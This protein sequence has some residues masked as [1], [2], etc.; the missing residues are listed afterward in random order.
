MS[1]RALAADAA[2]LGARLM[3]IKAVRRGL[4]LFVRSMWAPKSHLAE[5][6]ESDMAKKWTPSNDE[7]SISRELDD[8]VL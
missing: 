8:L 1:L 3:R 7:I 4:E 2:V 6:L 5:S